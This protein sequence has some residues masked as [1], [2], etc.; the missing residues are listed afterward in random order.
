MLHSNPLIKEHD[1][2]GIPILFLHVLIHYLFRRMPSIFLLD[3]NH[4]SICTNCLLYHFALYFIIST[5]FPHPIS[6]MLLLRL[7][8]IIPRMFSFSIA[9]NRW[10]LTMLQDILLQQSFTTLFFLFIHLWSF[11]RVF[12]QLDPPC[13]CRANFWL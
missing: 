2:V 10:C 6:C 13:F 11:L 9:M 7:L 3:G 8:L 1:N 5:S 4:L 12:F